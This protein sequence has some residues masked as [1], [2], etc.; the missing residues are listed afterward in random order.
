MFRY[1]KLKNYKSLVDF[2][3]DFTGKRNE[4]KKF[5]LIYGENGIGKSN[6]AS[7]FLTLYDIIQ[8]RLSMVDKTMFLEKLAEDKMAEDNFGILRGF[9]NNN[10]IDIKSIIN[11]CKTVNSDGNMMLEFGFRYKGKNG[12]YRIETDDE[13]IVSEKLDFVLNK[14][15]AEY[16]NITN[17]SMRIKESIFTDA[18]YYKEFKNTVKQYW[19]K[20]SLLAILYYETKEKAKNYVK[21]RII[22]NFY[23]LISMF[24][25]VS[26]YVNNTLRNK[27]GILTVKH[28]LLGMIESG[29]IKSKEKGELL[30]ME[31]FVDNFF[32]RTYS[33]IK[34]AYYK[35]EEKD[36]KISYQ[37]HFEKLIYGKIRDIDFR[38][39][40]AGT[41]HLLRVLP[42]MLTAV[43]KGTVIVDE[44]DSGIHDILIN[45]VLECLYPSI[46][47]QIILTTHNTYLL[48][49]EEF[50]KDSIYVFGVDADANKRL[51]PITDLEDRVHPN[52]NIRKRYLNGTYQGV[53]MPMDVDF[54]DLVEELKCG[55]GTP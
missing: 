38:V 27:K 45:N 54:E 20:H 32:T 34:R 11:T 8:T 14:N 28:K 49:S 7:S 43:E 26:L 13:Q 35:T 12:Y 15:Q 37:L 18:A 16:F 19:G 4:P 39:E 1:I 52:L 42:Y 33:D 10:F 21:N 53:P 23:D 25:E 29:I 24:N 36:G 47:G 40:S 2:E 30:K 5:V 46:N 41:Q 31:S 22:P 17:N 48:E 44:F 6:L 51:V 9:L 55:T 3:A 50:P